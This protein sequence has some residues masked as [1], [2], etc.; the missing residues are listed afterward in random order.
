MC[1][2]DSLPITQAN[3]KYLLYRQPWEIQLWASQSGTSN[4]NVVNYVYYHKWAWVLLKSWKVQISDVIHLHTRVAH[5]NL[6][7]QLSVMVTL[8]EQC[9]DDFKILGFAEW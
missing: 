3:I 8:F 6:L 1:R 5:K 4:K 7:Q 9:Q 2:A